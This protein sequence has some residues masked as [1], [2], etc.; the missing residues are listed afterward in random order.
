M[1]PECEWLFHR[2]RSNLMAGN[3]IER[4]PESKLSRGNEN[5]Y[6]E[7]YR[8]KVKE[9]RSHVCEDYPEAMP[10]STR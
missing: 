1:Y 5:D 7:V 9:M 2:V 10:A 6:L 4:V 8:S 3:P